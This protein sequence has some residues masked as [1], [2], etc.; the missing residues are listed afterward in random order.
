M[1]KEQAVKMAKA[2]LYNMKSGIDGLLP[3]LDAGILQ[4]EMLGAAVTT[5][6]TKA[7]DELDKQFLDGDAPPL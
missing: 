4:P 1:S 6:C 2:K 5:L 3:L 7:V